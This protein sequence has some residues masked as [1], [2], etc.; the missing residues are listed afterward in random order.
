MVLANLHEASDW[1]LV[2]CLLGVGCSPPFPSLDCG[3]AFD[4][5]LFCG[6]VDWAAHCLSS[7]WTGRGGASIYGKQFED[8]LHPDLKFTG[9]CVLGLG[10]QDKGAH[11]ES[12]LVWM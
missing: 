8:E 12:L 10:G 1:S 11:V 2:M 9:E 6:E 7:D 3:V 5:R 4:L